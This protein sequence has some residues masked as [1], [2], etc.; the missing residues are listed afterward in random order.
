MAV[1]PIAA[2]LP[3]SASAAGASPSPGLLARPARA[4][5]ERMEQL[6]MAVDVDGLPPEALAAVLATTRRPIV[7]SQAGLRGVCDRPGNLDDEQARGIAGTGGLV[8]IAFTPDAVCEPTLDA[9]VRSI[10]YAVDLVGVDHVA[11]GSNF[12]GLPTPIDA[13]GL[14]QLTQAL[15][16]A[17]I[18]EDDIARIAGANAWHFLRNLLPD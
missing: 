9:I 18:S 17:G 14:P 13:A 7:A 4:W 3:K 6:G 1:P 11:L 12:D 8:A 15:M 16:A 10:R 5:L 2:T